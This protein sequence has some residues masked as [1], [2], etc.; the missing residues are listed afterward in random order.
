MEPPKMCWARWMSGVLATALLVVSPAARAEAVRPYG[1]HLLVRVSPRDR[2]EVEQIWRLAEHVLEPHDPQ[3][4]PHTVLVSRPALER[5]HGLRIAAEVRGVDV[6]SLVDQAELRRRAPRTDGRLAPLA[7]VQRGRLGIFSAWFGRVQDLQAIEAHLDYL[8]AAA[9]GLARVVVIG[10]SVEGRPIPA[11]RLSSAT[12]VDPARAAI[13]VTGAQHAREW[14]TPMVAMGVAHALVHQLAFDERVRRVLAHVDVYVVP[15][16]NVDGYVASHEGRRFQRKNMNRGCGVDLNR[17]FDVEFGMGS[18][19]AGCNDE[20]FPGAGPFSEPESQA[21]KA[22]ADGLPG[23]RLYL[24]YHAP[25]EQVMIPFAHTRARPPGYEKSRAWGE[26][27]A[28]SLKDVHGTLHPARDGFDL[29]QGQGGGAIDWFRVNT[30]E[31]FAIELRDGRD[32][33]GFELPAEQI[34]PTVEENWLAWLTL[35]QEVAR[36]NPAATPGRLPPAAPAPALPVAPPDPVAG[37]RAAAV[38]GGGCAAAGAPAAAAPP[39]ALIVGAFALLAR[40]RG[41]GRADR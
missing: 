5:L 36:E 9:S 10:H 33:G 4:A 12:A 34:I 6:Q 16:V 27:Y 1:E 13:L 29:A 3:V 28:A 20:N 23:L 7:A 37:A 38:G 39:L 22:L 8:A 26:L 18:A 40:R 30:V 41:R 31:A 19:S 32:L 25:A 21:V 11:L 17:N 14:A 2:A 24:D 35:A 15:V